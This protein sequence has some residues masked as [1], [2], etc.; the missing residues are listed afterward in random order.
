[1]DFTQDLAALTAE[2]ASLLEALMQ[3]DQENTPLATTPKIVKIQTSAT[4]K[5]LFIIHG[6][7][8]QVLFLHTL[9]T[10]ISPAQPLYGIEAAIC[11]DAEAC[12]RYVEALRAVQ[13]HG[14]YH[15]G[16][17]SAGCLIA[18]EVAAQL[19]DA[20]EEVAFLLL[21]DPISITA[22]HRLQTPR[23]RLHKRFEI[24][25]LAGVTPL[26]PEFPIIEQLSR[27]LTNL[28]QHFRNQPLDRRI[29]II[30]GTRGA[31]VP[32]AKTLQQWSTLAGSGLDCAT[33]EADHFE[34]VRDPHA[35][36]TG[37]QIQSWLDAT[38]TTLSTLPL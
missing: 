28:A 5:P 37:A 17:Y 12:S 26:S 18:F 33:I 8:G 24:A 38:S 20:G 19:R 16:G 34:I 23:Q 35:A 13:P 31:Y 25:R 29:H 15:L 10:H 36:L 27:H 11:G 14:P 4:K 1:M 6:T 32:S 7:G 22:T 21:I 3:D 30:H 9:A 2:Q